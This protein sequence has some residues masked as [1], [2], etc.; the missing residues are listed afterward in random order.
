VPLTVTRS[1]N[2]GRWW[3][4]RSISLVQVVDPTNISAGDPVR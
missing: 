3:A 2:K 1:E 4:D